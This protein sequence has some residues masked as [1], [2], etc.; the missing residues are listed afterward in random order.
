MMIMPQCFDCRRLLERK[1]MFCPAFPD[2]EGIP[3]P[4]L[5]NE[6]DHSTPFPGDHGLLFEPKP[7]P[8]P[9]SSKGEK[10]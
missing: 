2:G 4:I 7:K 10:A 9:I 8:K 1:G 3:D 5:F 6:H